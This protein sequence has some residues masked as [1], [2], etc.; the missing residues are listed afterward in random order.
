MD[1]YSHL[2]SESELRRQQNETTR[3]S[4]KLEDTPQLDDE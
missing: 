4:R 1:T 2:R 3:Q